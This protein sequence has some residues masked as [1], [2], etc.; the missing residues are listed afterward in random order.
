[1]PDVLELFPDRVTP[2]PNTGCWIW[3]GAKDSNGYGLIRREKKGIAMHRFSYGLTRTPTPG[4]QIMHRCDVK[5]CV[6]PE[7]LEEGS[8]QKNIQD[9]WDRGLMKRRTG[10]ELP[11]TKLTPEMLAEIRAVKGRFARGQQAEMAARFG[12]TEVTIRA[13]RQRGS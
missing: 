1:M 8:N 5:L 7:H 10:M 2:E 4:M 6:N 12:V 11:W 3:T 13:A 9:A